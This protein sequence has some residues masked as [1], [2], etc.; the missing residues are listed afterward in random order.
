MQRSGAID[1]PTARGRVPVGKYR[2]ARSVQ[3]EQVRERVLSNGIFKCIVDEVVQGC[4]LVDRPAEGT[5][6]T[7]THL[8]IP[9][10]GGDFC[11]RIHLVLTR[12]GIVTL[13]SSRHLKDAAL[14]VIK[15]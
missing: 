8:K 5:N 12:A 1:R 13:V 10:F 2:L 3:T 14:S 7:L 15:E 11:V 4:I 6:D 9:D